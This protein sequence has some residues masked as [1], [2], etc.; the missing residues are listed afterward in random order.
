MYDADGELIYSG[1]IITRDDSGSETDFAPLDDF[2]KPNAGC[3]EIWYED[4]RG[5]WSEL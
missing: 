1:R 5:N 3:T 2:G 4:A